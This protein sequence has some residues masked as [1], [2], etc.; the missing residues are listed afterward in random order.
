MSKRKPLIRSFLNGKPRGRDQTMP[1]NEEAADDVQLLH[2]ISFQMEQEKSSGSF[3]VTC[4][5]EHIPCPIVE[6]ED[7]RPG[8]KKRP[9]PK[10]N[11][12]LKEAERAAIL[13]PLTPK[14]Y[15]QLVDEH[16]EILPLVYKKMDK[17][18][19]R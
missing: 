5:G 15:R 7:V 1:A 14:K 12:A 9:S 10:Y 17:N 18:T 19:S 11:K 2:E 13:K 8:A 3:D 16:L 4:P 6:K